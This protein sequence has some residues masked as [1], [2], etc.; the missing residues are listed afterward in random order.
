MKIKEVAKNIVLGYIYKITDIDN[1][2]IDV[3][4]E[5]YDINHNDKVLLE[6]CKLINEIMKKAIKEI[7]GENNEY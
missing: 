7:E 2:N 4:S 3:L 1:I 6:H 5:I